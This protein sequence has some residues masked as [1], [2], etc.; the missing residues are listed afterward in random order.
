MMVT[1]VVNAVKPGSGFTLLFDALVMM[2]ESEI[3]LMRSFVRTLAKQM[4]VEAIA[5]LVGAF[6]DDL[7][8]H[9]GAR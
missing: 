3:R 9:G 4:A 2:G 8:K 6:K 5:R 1:P 7:E